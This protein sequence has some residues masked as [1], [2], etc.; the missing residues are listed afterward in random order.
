MKKETIERYIKEGRGDWWFRPLWQKIICVILTPF[1]MLW[2]GFCWCI[3]KLGRGFY[4]LGDLLSGWK[5]D[6]DWLQEL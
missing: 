5:W 3:M 1:I 6:G 2:F 4:Q